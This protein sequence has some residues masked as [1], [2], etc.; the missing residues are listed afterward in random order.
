MDVM[1]RLERYMMKRLLNRMVRM[2]QG[3]QE[4]ETKDCLPAFGTI[5]TSTGI[6]LMNA[7]GG[8]MI[9]GNDDTMSAAR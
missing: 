2:P 4:I 9:V 1:G 6:T 8:L 7:T 5:S 3:Q